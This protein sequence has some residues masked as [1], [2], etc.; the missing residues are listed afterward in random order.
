MEGAKSMVLLQKML[1]DHIIERLQ[2]GEPMQ[3]DYFPSVTILFSDVVN[4]TV[5]SSNAPSEMVRP[6]PRPA[7][8]ARPA[9]SGGW[10]PRARPPC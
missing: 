4:Y 2:N 9:C 7:R 5:M 10:P 3:L 6:A 8:P 1:P